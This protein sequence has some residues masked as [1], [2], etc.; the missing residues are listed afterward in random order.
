MTVEAA[1]ATLELD[2]AKRARTII[3]VDEGRGTLDDLNWLL[4]RGYLVMAKEYSGRR[5]LRLA[6]TVTEWVQDPVW[7]ERSFGWA[8]PPAVGYVRPVRRLA[9]RGLRQDGTFAGRAC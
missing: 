8:T 3:R 5:V 4:A 1:E 2:A 9:V 6:K 7:P